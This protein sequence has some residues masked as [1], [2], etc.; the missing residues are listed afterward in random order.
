MSS[1]QIIRFHKEERIIEGI[2]FRWYIIPTDPYLWYHFYI[3]HSGRN[4]MQ[5]SKVTSVKIALVNVAVAKTLLPIN[6]SKA[7]T[8]WRTHNAGGEGL[9]TWSGVYRTLPWGDLNSSAGTAEVLGHELQG[10]VYH[11]FMLCSWRSS[12]RTSLPAAV[13]EMRP[14]VVMINNGEPNSS[15]STSVDFDENDNM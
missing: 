12:I 10:N 4:P 1:S 13:H 7:I 15:S 9:S 14:R 5:W 6:A 11:I 2:L 8:S 3:E